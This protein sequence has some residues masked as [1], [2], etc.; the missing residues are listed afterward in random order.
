[1]TISFASNSSWSEQCT[2]TAPSTTSTA[3][4]RTRSRLWYSIG[5]AT[6]T[7]NLL[8]TRVFTS[9]VYINSPKKCWINLMR[10]WCRCWLTKSLW[11]YLTIGCRAPNSSAPNHKS[12]SRTSSFLRR[13]LSCALTRSPTHAASRRTGWSN[14]G[15]AST[16]RT[17]TSAIRWTVCCFICLRATP[18]LIK[19][20]KNSAKSSRA[21]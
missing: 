5:C 4:R 21:T 8:L 6:T 3:S 2:G 18:P 7:I 15:T 14:T 13:F 10:Q 9:F 12:P 11:S 1:M 19:S 16:T 20:L 17:S